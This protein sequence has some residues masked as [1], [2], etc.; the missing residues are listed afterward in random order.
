M[1]SVP[2]SLENTKAIRRH[3]QCH[4]SIKFTHVSPTP[5]LSSFP[6]QWANS[7]RYF[8]RLYFCT[9]SYSSIDSRVM[10]LQFITLFPRLRNFLSTNQ[11]YQIWNTVRYLPFFKRNS[12]NEYDLP[13]TAV[14]LFTAKHLE[15]LYQ[16]QGCDFLGYHSPLDPQKSVFFLH[17]LLKLF[18]VGQES[19]VKLQ[20][21]PSI[22]LS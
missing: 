12:I 20:V 10:I 21:I 4:F 3:M 11:S 15:E 19:F 14:I 2:I 13:F 17:G 1:I 6:L 22:H 16:T 9:R 8:F 5:N 18:C 7:F